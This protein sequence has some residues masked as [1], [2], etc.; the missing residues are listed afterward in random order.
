MK[1]SRVQRGEMERPT[2]HIP[3][4]TWI[5][6]VSP[7]GLIQETLWPD[8][9]AILVSCV[10]LN[11]TTRRAAEKVLPTFLGRWPRAS[12]LIDVDPLDI[13][14]VVGVLGLGKRRSKTLKDMSRV[15]VGG[16]W[17]HASE[18]PGIGSY[19]SAAHDIFVRGV[20]PDEC[21]DDHALTLWWKWWKESSCQ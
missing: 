4:A 18:L 19:G 17:K 10:M 20:I 9:W 15:Y 8:E 13:E 6:P 7:Y 12:D 16:A 1:S 21:P 14:G 5:P 3:R 11:C 2:T